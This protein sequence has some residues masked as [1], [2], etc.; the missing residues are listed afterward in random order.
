M[1]SSTAHVK[2]FPMIRWVLRRMRDG[3]W[4]LLNND[5]EPGVCFIRHSETK[6]VAFSSVVPESYEES[7]FFD[8]WLSVMMK[9]YSVIAKRFWR[10]ARQT[11]TIRCLVFAVV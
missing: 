5:K 1:K 9:A 2:T 3:R 8:L 11:N 7:H 6:D 4:T 10:V